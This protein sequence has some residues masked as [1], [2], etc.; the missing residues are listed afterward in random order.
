MTPRTRRTLSLVLL[1]LAL[2]A[3]LGLAAVV[4]QRQALLRG[5]L[6]GLPKMSLPPRVPVLGV[7]ADLTQY[8]DA[9]LA[10]NLD[11]IAGVGF[12]WVRQP[13]RWAE[14]EL[15]P[16]RFEW[17]AYDRVV[18]EAAARDLRLVAVLVD[19]PGWAADAPTAPPDDLDAFASFAATLSERYGE[20]IDVYQ[21]WDEPNLSS[22]W[23][24][25][26]PSPVRYA[27]LLQAA[28]EAIH[29]VDADALV[30]TAGLAPTVERGPENLS[31][32]L[33]LRELYA[34]GAA[35]FFDGV[36]GKPYGFDDGPLE[37]RTHENVLNFSRLVLLREVMVEHG[38]AGKP[39]WA[40][41]FGW[42]ALPEGWQGA[43]SAWGQTT[44]AQQAAWTLDAYR[45]ALTEWPWAGA[46]ILEN[47]QPAAEPDDPRW[48]FALRGQD[49]ALSP[50]AEAIR[51]EAAAINGSLWPGVYAADVPL[52]EYE[53]EWE[54]SELGADI[55]QQGDSVVTVPFTGSSLGVIARRDNYRAYLY[56]TVDGEPPGVL[57]HDERGAYAVLTSPDYQPRIEVLPLA[58]GLEGDE[59]HVARIEA[60]RGWDQWAIAGFAVGHDVDTT[61]HDVLA[62][63][64]LVLA[65]ASVIG[66]LRVGRGLGWRER[67][68][69]A[70]GWLVSRL[71]EGVHLLLSLASALAVWLGAALTW[72]GLV[73]SLTRRLGEG[74]SLIVTALTAGVFY[75]SPWL[76]LTLAALA[77]LFVLI[78]TRLS[79]G[80]A[81][82]MFFTPFYL[83]PRPLF[84]RAFSMV[85]VL[86]L[87]TLAA[88]ALRIAADR[89][90]TGWPSLAGLWR[91]MT[92]L[93]KAVGLFIAVSVVSLAWADLL[94][95]AVTELR[96]MVIEPFVVYLVLRT[97]PFTR[98]ER[99]RMVDLL[100]LTGAVVSV[101]GLAQFVAGVNVIAA[102]GGMPRLQSVF[103]TPNNAALFLGRVVPF[104]AAALLIDRGGWRR[105]L[106]GVAAFVMALALGL[107]LS[108]GGILLGLPAGLAMVVILWAG[109]KGLIAV[110]A[111]AI[112]E[113]LALIPLSRL[114]RF[115][116]LIDFTSGTS[117]TFFRLQLW[118][119][120]L[121]MIRDHP[122]TGV[123]LDQFLYEYRGR[124][125]LPSAWQQP[126]LSQPHNFLLNYWVRLGIIGLIAGIWMQVAFWRLGWRVQERLRGADAGMRA[127]AVG[128]MGSMAAMIAHGMVDAVHFVIDLA[129]IFYMTLGLMSQLGEEVEHGDADQRADA[130]ARGG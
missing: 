3:A 110:V 103:G 28:Y 38:D 75:F 62:G 105:W 69:T 36:A 87:L 34:N 47:W 25:R 91:R 57:P 92:S 111:G 113:A 6:D 46:L 80:V 106:Y 71:G 124:Y 1:V 51:A 102:E 39:L 70:A 129:F 52:A 84:D 72:G 90:E 88:W 24:G 97:V 108:K 53:G 7:N 17:A 20:T 45:R 125:I 15:E 13:F 66:A 41:H 10:E 104:G 33:F 76:L 63:M 121:R 14:I 74:P 35:P 61:G 16:G 19:S 2:L 82:I 65:A 37:R 127:L 54:F 86:S 50:T 77:L 128:A 122:I 107:T 96:Q 116:G 73:P 94:G 48:G 4:S 32:V 115:S 43:P 5:T 44:P 114:P 9:A 117:T 85:E 120:T 30:L 93:D 126:D 49:G 59:R 68:R 11:L 99:W 60:E 42:N 64:L 26:E 56:V 8:D 55:G 22:G 100:V 78:Y 40:S 29:A 98:A 79:V 81:L 118:K 101:I 130:G 18:E 89:R 23:G 95:V 119:S 58:D 112:L 31:D 83:H 27:A 21:V 123:G 109:R 67:V 12:V